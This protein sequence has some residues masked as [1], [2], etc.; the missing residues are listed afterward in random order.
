MSGQQLPLIGTR[1]NH[2]GFLGTVRFAGNVHHTSG[3]WLGV[4]W[5]DPHR[6]KH[7][8][9]KDGVRYFSCLVP[10][11]GSFIRPSPTI[12]YGRSFLTAMYAKYIEM[13]HGEALEKLILGSSH[14][15]IEVEAVGLDRIRS[16]LAR[17]ERLREVSLDGESVA[18]AD[19][20]GAV[21]DTCSS[22]RGLDLS[23]N[24]IPSWDVVAQVTFELPHLRAL[25][26]NQNRLRPVTNRVLAASAFRNLRE[27]QLNATLTTWVDMQ[28]ATSAM[29]VLETVEMGYNR[30]ESLSP[31]SDDDSGAPPNVPPLRELNFDSNGLH[32]WPVVCHALRPYTTLQ[33]L[34]LPSNCVETIEPL[35]DLSQS[36]IAGLKHLSL[37]FNRLSAWSDIDRLPL[38]CPVLESLA[39]AGNPVTEA[40]AASAH[41]RQ[42][43]IARIPSLT[44]LDAAPISN[45]ERVDSELFYLSYVS[46]HG[47]LDEDALCREHPRWRA[48]CEKHG[49]PDH[50]PAAS[51]DR[52]DTLSSRLIQVNVRQCV[53]GLSKGPN[54][55]TTG[56][57]MALRVLPTMSMRTFSMKVAKSFKIPRAAQASLRIRLQ[58]PDDH[59]ALVDQDDT[60]DLDWWG[61]DN[62]ADIYI[63]LEQT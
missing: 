41:A 33:R 29:P 62:N 27:L 18:A 21:A 44:S 58:M 54:T 63:S 14:G 48:L 19:P 8:G 34:V 51:R 16:K 1:I 60:H 6:G 10:N 4:E 12:S 57:A 42:F 28:L 43:A 55:T 17:L 39:L 36:P 25:A 38:W 23:K 50:T 5:D 45:K 40:E 24:L 32:S 35:A 11:S 61:V 3:V 13:P 15:A 9:V 2:S 52:P 22:M 47:P 26:L 20:P 7:D 31:G 37:S 56:P 30:L 46:K 53:D 49:R 59:L